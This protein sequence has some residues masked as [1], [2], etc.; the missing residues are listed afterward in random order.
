[1]SNTV[2]GRPSPEASADHVGGI[3]TFASE[4]EARE[5]WDQHDSAPVFERG[6]DVSASPPDDLR[7]G[8][9]REGSRARRRPPEGRMD[10]VS[11][12]LPTELI[13]GVKALAAARHLPYQT[14]MRSWLRERLEE[15]RAAGR[16]SP[17]GDEGVPDESLVDIPPSPM[18]RSGSWR[19]R[20]D[21]A[22]SQR[23][24]LSPTPSA[25]RNA[26]C[27]GSR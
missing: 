20:P 3:P 27:P 16:R 11:L 24:L 1:L 6:D 4:E 22:L 18:S 10:L 17:R 7:L 8:P 25:D 2:E 19:G 9:G 26:P 5:F 21:R 23:R 13:D 12:R 15:E 14:L